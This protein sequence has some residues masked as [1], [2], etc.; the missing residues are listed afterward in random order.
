MIHNNE[1]FN[2]LKTTKIGIIAENYVKSYLES[3][4][5]KLYWNTNTQSQP[6]DGIGYSG[7]T[8]KNLIEVKAKYPMYNGCVSIHENDLEAYEEIQIEESKEMLL[9]YVDHKNKQLLVTT[10]KR[11]RKSTKNRVWDNEE[12]KWLIYF[13][14]LVKRAELPYHVAEEMWNVS[15]QI[16][17]R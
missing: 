16:Q 3:I 17:R 6:F 4:G 11:I 9:I 13:D 7:K 5:Y 10:T 15:K 1:Q 8:V 12:K 14:N 2:E